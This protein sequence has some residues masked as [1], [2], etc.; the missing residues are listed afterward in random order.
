MSVS[1][2]HPGFLGRLKPYGGRRFL[3]LVGALLGLL[4]VEV[5][6][7]RGRDPWDLMTDEKDTPTREAVLSYLRSQ[8]DIPTKVF[9]ETG[10]DQPFGSRKGRV[11]SLQIKR[12][13]E[14][15]RA[16]FDFITD[17]D[18]ARYAIEVL[19]NHGHAE[20]TAYCDG[21]RVLKAS[22]R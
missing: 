17:P 20:A 13:S 11:D 18:R 2:R 5:I 16:R 22:R 9:N 14:F 19:I 15:T 6:C 7:R 12:C 10:L 3:L 1:G 8:A 21:I 4:L